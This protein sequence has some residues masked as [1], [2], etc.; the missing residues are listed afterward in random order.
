MSFLFFSYLDRDLWSLQHSLF[1]QFLKSTLSRNWN[2]LI[3]SF[4]KSTFSHIDI[5]SHKVTVPKKQ[6]SRHSDTVL[7]V[8]F[9]INLFPKWTNQLLACRGFSRGRLLTGGDCWDGDRGSER[10]WWVSFS[11]NFLRKKKLLFPSSL[12][13]W[14]TFQ[15]RWG[16]VC[17]R[18]AS[19]AACRLLTCHQEPWSLG[20][21]RL[22]KGCY[23]AKDSNLSVFIRYW[24][25]LICGMKGIISDSPQ[26]FSTSICK[27]FNINTHYQTNDKNSIIFNFVCL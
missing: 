4:L 10:N 2:W 19:Q 8:G 17:H 21:V 15:A 25:H 16:W 22:K 18:A 26:S 6:Q 23:C 24:L 3:H 20:W 7:Y 9:W 11:L 14:N 27:T 13:C 12:L 1:L 5:Q